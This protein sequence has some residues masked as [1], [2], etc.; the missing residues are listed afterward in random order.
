MP[1]LTEIPASYVRTARRVLTGC[2][3]LP[4]YDAD[5]VVQ[6]SLLA[7]Y[8]RTGRWSV[9][10]GDVPIVLHMVTARGRALRRTRTD[11]VRVVDPTDALDAL[12]VEDPTT[13]VDDADERRWQLGRLAGAIPTLPPAQRTAV[14]DRL[15]GSGAGG[16]A[17][18]MAHSAA[19]RN[20]RRAIEGSTHS[21]GGQ[22]G[23]RD[24]RR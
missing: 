7:A 12:V 20:L 9:E 4:Y 17:E 10:P 3:P 13:A 18:R 23:Q 8:Q 19:V 11:L 16:A 15:A 2:T 21:V 6:D 1:E 24:N 5:D 14:T 22:N